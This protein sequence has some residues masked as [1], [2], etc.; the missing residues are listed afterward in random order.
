V[1]YSTD[2][3]WNSWIKRGLQRVMS[4][5][6]N[7]ESKV[8][9]QDHCVPF[10]PVQFRGVQHLSHSPENESI[11]NAFDTPLQGLWGSTQ[12]NNLEAT[13]GSLL[14]ELGWGD[15]QVRKQT[16]APKREKISQVATNTN[17]ANSTDSNV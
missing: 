15:V 2:E 1:N 10:L 12:D 8:Q 7:I 11:T 17:H 4:S 9:K 13:G 16:K 5:M 6:T 3:M 14:D